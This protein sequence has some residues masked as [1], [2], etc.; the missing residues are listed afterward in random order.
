MLL[1]AERLRA[2]PRR[3]LV[4]EDS[5]PGLQAGYRAGMRVVFVPDVYPLPAW[6]GTVIPT[7]NHLAELLARGM[8]PGQGSLLRDSQG[9]ACWA[10]R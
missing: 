8:V 10:A 6:R 7:L 5:A 9:P 3:C 4:I 1:A 2:D